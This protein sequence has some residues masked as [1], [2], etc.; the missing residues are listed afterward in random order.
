[1]ELLPSE[2]ELRNRFDFDAPKEKWNWTTSS[3]LRNLYDYDVE[4]Y[5]AVQIGKALTS[6]VQDDIGVIKR[7]SKGKN[8]YFI[9]PAIIYTDRFRN[10]TD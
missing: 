7:R 4:R 8:Q 5:S 1:M 6:I 2:E 9:P 3:A 10:K